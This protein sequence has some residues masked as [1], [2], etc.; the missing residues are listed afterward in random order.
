[1]SGYTKKQLLEKIKD[2]SFKDLLHEEKVAAIK[3]LSGE[4]PNTDDVYE[5]SYETSYESSYES[6]FDDS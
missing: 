3:V 6:S 5:L 4:A 2:G 1:M